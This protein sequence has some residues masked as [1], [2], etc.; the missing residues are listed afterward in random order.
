MSGSMI[1]T[2]LNTAFLLFV[3]LGLGALAGYFCE[4][5]GIVNIAID[6]QM[7]FGAFIFTI[8]GMLLNQWLPNVGGLFFLV[9]LVISLL[10]SVL[11]SWLFGFLVIKLKSDHVISG[12]AINL[13]VAGLG[14]FITA[15]LGS[16]ISG[17]V[18]PKLIVS[19]PPNWKIE[20]LLGSGSYFSGETIIIFSLAIIV[21]LISIFVIN[22]TRLGLRFK[23]V[24]DNPNAV[25]A[26]GLN[27]NKYKW[28]GVLISGAFAA[29]AG[30]I[31]MYGGVTMY[32]QSIYFE[33]NVAGLGFLALAIVVSGAWRIP[34]I[35]V[36]AIAFA[37]LVAV[38]NR[39]VVIV[40]EIETAI[41][42]YANYITKAIPFVI[43]LLVL[44]IFSWRGIAA[45][46]ALG[47]HFDKSLR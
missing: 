30:S 27:V 1:S 29:A 22:R 28:M 39:A 18:S 36:S 20:G 26:Q 31:F 37:I 10:I 13:V 12:T 34:F 40:P 24:G 46:K 35:T 3:V 6:G 9:P 43:S 7:I 8:F 33:G 44:C 23:A 15:P 2:L 38:F 32:P 11:L 42:A 19:F 41:G 16:A 14:T 47:S 25:D 5:V 21:I 4:R 17:G 45:P